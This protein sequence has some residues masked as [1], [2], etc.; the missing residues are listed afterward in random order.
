MKLRQAPFFSIEIAGIHTDS[1]SRAE[2][3][4]FLTAVKM[5]G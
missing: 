4:R 3:R 2:S 1:F 5:A